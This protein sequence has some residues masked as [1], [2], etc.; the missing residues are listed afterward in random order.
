MD[1][2]I[3]VYLLELGTQKQTIAENLIVK[4]K[5]VISTQVIAENINVCIRKLSY[6]KE[7][8]FQHAENLIAVCDLAIINEQILRKAFKVSIQYQYRYF[9]SLIIATALENQCT[10]LY[11]EDM[12]HDQIIDNQLTIINPF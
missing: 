3:C 5:P 10:I 7:D 6:P 4:A 11:S 12:Q 2:N 9:D 8:A 1:S